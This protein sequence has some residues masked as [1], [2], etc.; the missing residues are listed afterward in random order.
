MFDADVGGK[1]AHGELEEVGADGGEGGGAPLVS[2][3]SGGDFL[4]PPL[5]TTCASPCTWPCPVSSA[6]P[7]SSSGG[8]PCTLVVFVAS[9]VP[10]FDFLFDVVSTFVTGLT[11]GFLIAFM[12][13]ELLGELEPAKKGGELM[14][15]S[16]ADDGVPAT[17][18][19]RCMGAGVCLVYG[20]V[21]ARGVRACA[22]HVAC[23][24]CGVRGVRSVG[25]AGSVHGVYGVHAGRVCFDW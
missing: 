4:P 7:F 21:G 14:T 11:G 8:L 12:M 19:T 17:R 5:D 3:N 16:D 2:T 24:V 22:V 6:V 13:G 1:C 20:S 15:I 23:A 10:L 25:A 9:A 18:R